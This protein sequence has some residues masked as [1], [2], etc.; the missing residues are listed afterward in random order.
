[1]AQNKPIPESPL[2]WMPKSVW[3]PLL[4][5]QLHA[6]A[7]A[8]LPMKGEQEW[9]DAFLISI[10][11]PH[12]QKHFNLFMDENPPDLSDRPSMFAWTVAAHNYV[13]R[14]KH[15][16]ELTLEQALLSHSKAILK[17]D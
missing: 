3:G 15:K 13:N 2:F 8:Y 10:P 11:C 9:L 4:W 14:S 12:C 1:M 5:Q 6:R 16:E 17:Q 7:L